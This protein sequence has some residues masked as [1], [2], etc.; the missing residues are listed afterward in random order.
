LSAAG[1]R[2][3]ALVG[4]EEDLFN[5]FNRAL[6]RIVQRHTN[7]SRDVV[8]DACA[9]AWQQ[10]LQ[11]QPDRDR[12]WRAWLV[13][14][15]EREAWRLDGIDRNHASLSID[16]LDWVAPAEWDVPDRDRA[17]IR[18]RLRD[19]LEAFSRLPERRRE[20]KALQI[21]GFSYEE[22][23]EMRGL[24]YTRVNHILAE[25]N[26]TLREQQARGA[27]TVDGSPR[28][29]RLN[30]LEQDPPRWLRRA[31]GR[32][33]SITNE[34]QAV[35]AWRRAALTID[36]YRRVY[37]RGL[38]DEPIGD[39]PTELEAARAFDVARASIARAV[40]ARSRPP[41]RGLER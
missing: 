27:V 13:K 26:A 11:H 9:F 3:P 39:R 16:D 23:A 8:D 18:M 12:N 24:T 1:G 10:F 38:G 4:D 33:P 14:T 28:A 34:R 29:R 40:E 5:S 22:I 2:R 30:E 7:T 20:I 37:G 35:L 31:I 41:H 25:A 17:A 6:V 21:T 36:D 32:L 19:A 15:A